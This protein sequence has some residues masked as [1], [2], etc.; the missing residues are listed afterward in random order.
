MVIVVKKVKIMANK[1]KI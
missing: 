1:M